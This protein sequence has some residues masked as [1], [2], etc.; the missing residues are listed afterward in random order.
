MGIQ[1]RL[2]FCANCVIP[3]IRGGRGIGSEV[4]VDH[5]LSHVTRAASLAH[6][7]QVIGSSAQYLGS[8]LVL[9]EGVGEAE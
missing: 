1:P 7:V 2:A 5:P 4:R 3:G 8:M 6:A 9:R